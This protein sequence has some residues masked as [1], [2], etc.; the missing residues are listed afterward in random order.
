MRHSISLA[1]VVA[2]VV[3]V[4]GGVASCDAPPKQ[5]VMDTHVLVDA[6]GVTTPLVCPGAKGCTTASGSLRVVAAH[7]AITPDVGGDAKP[8]YLAGFGP[9]RAATDVHDDVEARVLVVE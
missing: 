5:L 1:V 6:R 8:V 9:G 7:R 4:V 2:G 3:V